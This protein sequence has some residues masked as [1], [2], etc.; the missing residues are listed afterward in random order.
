M[1]GICGGCRSLAVV[2]S[3]HIREIIHQFSARVCDLQTPTTPTVPTSRFHIFGV[4][5]LRSASRWLLLQSA[6]THAPPR[7][8]Q[9]SAASTELADPKPRREK[10]T[11]AR[12]AEIAAVFAERCAGAR[13]SPVDQNLT[14]ARNSHTASLKKSSRYPHSS[15]PRPP[16]SAAPYPPREFLINRSDATGFFGAQSLSGRCSAER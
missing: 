9:P 13:G 15:P 12:D 11:D 4:R 3:A 16:V 10:M 14:S 7:C 2:N 8:W 1:S 6:G 5:T